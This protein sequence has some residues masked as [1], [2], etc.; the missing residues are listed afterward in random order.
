[1][2]L[3]FNCNERADGSRRYEKLK[4]ETINEH[5]LLY[6]WKGSNLDLKPLLFM[7]HTDVRVSQ[8][9]RSCGKLI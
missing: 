9:A 3:A 6:T 7:G 4:V 8:I 2:S 1:M 5:A